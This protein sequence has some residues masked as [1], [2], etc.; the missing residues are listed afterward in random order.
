MAEYTWVLETGELQRKSVEISYYQI[1]ESSLIYFL[2]DAM[3]QLHNNSKVEEIKKYIYSIETSNVNSGNPSKMVVCLKGVTPGGRADKYPS[4]FRIQ[5]KPSY[6]NDAYE[7]ANK[8]NVKGILLGI[9]KTEEL[10]EPIYCAWKLKPSQ[11]ESDKPVSKQIQAE[12]I[13]EAITNGFAIAKTKNEY[14]CA[15]RKE[16]IFFYLQNS[17]WIHDHQ[18]EKTE[19]K[20]VEETVRD[21][22]IDYHTPQYLEQPGINRIY[23]GAPGTGKS[24]GIKEFI[25]EH[26]IADYNDKNAYPNVFRTTLHPEYGYND[27]VGQVMPVVKLDEESSSSIIEYEFSPQVF[28]KALDKAFRIRSSKEPVFLILEEMSRA[29]VAGVFGDL[30][31]LLDRDEQGVSE[32][33]VDNALIAESI[34]GR[35]RSDDKIYLPENIFILGTVNTS[36]QNVY[37]MDTA[38]KRRFEFEYVSTERIIGSLNDFKFSLKLNEELLE[39][40]WITLISKLNA[41]IVKSEEHGGL[42]LSEDK[43]IGQ[44]FIKFKLN[45]GESDENIIKQLEEYNYNQIK[46]KL[47]Q[48]LWHDVKGA[49]YSPQNLFVEEASSFSKLYSMAEKKENF[50]SSQFLDI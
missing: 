35:D 17:E 38:F 16:F 18:F 33:R 19:K 41:Y 13:A 27:F 36:D 37:V 2:E 3:N 26:G 29:N 4:E 8:D 42:G 30:F 34:F 7:I 20:L 45:T 47:L 6:L 40:S 12:T 43:Q 25:R 5:Q 50:F 48:Y 44:F 46:G 15:F 39:F 32:Y 14:V 10:S 1:V 9:Y 31:Q 22:I 23:F 21:S 24:F 28:T 49:S 11:K